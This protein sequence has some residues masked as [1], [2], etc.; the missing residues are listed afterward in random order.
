MAPRKK[1]PSKTRQ[2]IDTVY[3]QNELASLK[4][5]QSRGRSI[6]VGNVSGGLIEISIRSEFS[7]LYYLLHPVE[8]VEVIEQIAAAAGLEIAKRPKQDFTSWRSWDLEQPDISHWKGTAPWQIDDN[9][10][11]KMIKFEQKK[12]G[13]LPAPSDLV[14]KPKLEAT[15]KRK[16]TVQEEDTEE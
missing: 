4:A 13:V 3:E 5:A 2:E 8:A 9:A 12:F 15:T 1:Q 14:E 10:K 7:T 16:K 11:K 6:C